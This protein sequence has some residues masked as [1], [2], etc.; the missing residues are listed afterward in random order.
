MQAIIFCCNHAALP[1]QLALEVPFCMLPL[2]GK[3][4]VDRAVESVVRAGAARI[5]VILADHPGFRGS[6]LQG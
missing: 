1:E 4:L 3:P 5:T 2:V 6:G